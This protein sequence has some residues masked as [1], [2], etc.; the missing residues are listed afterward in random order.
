MLNNCRHTHY[1]YD[2]LTELRGI[3][4]YS[5]LMD[6]V[7]GKNPHK[8]V[9]FKTAST[10]TPTVR[11]HKPYRGLLLTMNLMSQWFLVVKLK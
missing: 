4:H 5:F 3:F 6:E 11:T 8:Y 2:I 1:V 10:T 7:N 9:T